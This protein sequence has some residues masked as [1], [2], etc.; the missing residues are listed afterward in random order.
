MEMQ[1]IGKDLVLPD[2][3][4]RWIW[5]PLMQDYFTVLFYSLYIIS[6]FYYRC[7][8]TLFYIL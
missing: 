6:L 1:K 7:Y 3:L 5:E 8:G 4:W 2:G